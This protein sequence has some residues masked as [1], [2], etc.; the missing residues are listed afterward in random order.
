MAAPGA[1][2]SGPATSGIVGPVAHEVGLDGVEQHEPTGQ[3]PVALGDGDGVAPPR[4]TRVQRVEPV[5]HRP[6][7]VGAGAGEDGVDRLHVLGTADGLVGDHDHLGQDL[8]AEDDVAPL[9]VVGGVRSGIV[10]VTLV[11]DVQHGGQCGRQGVSPPVADA[12]T[13]PGCPGSVP[14]RRRSAVTPARSPRARRGGTPATPGSTAASTPAT[15]DTADQDR[16]PART[17]CVNTNSSSDSSADANAHAHTRPRTSPTAPPMAAMITDSQRTERRSCRRVMPMARSM[18]ISWVRSYTDSASVFTIP[19]TA[20]ELR[21]EQQ[22]HRD[23]EELVDELGLGV[24]RLVCG[25][26]LD[27]REVVAAAPR[28]TASRARAHASTPGR[29]GRVGAVVEVGLGE[30]GRGTAR[31]TRGTASRRRRRHRRR[32]PPPAPART[33]FGNSSGDLVTEGEAVLDRLLLR[34]EHPVVAEVGD[35]AARASAG[36]RRRRAR[37]RSTAT[38]RSSSRRVDD[39]A[40]RPKRKPD[41]AGD[42]GQRVDAGDDVGREPGELRGVDDEVGLERRSRTRRPAPWP[43]RRGS[44]PSRPA[45]GRSRARSRWPRCDAGCASR[46][47]A[48]SRPVTP[49][50]T[51]TGDA[52]HAARAGGRTWRAAPRCRRRGAARRARRSAAR[53]WR[54][55]PTAARAM[56]TSEHRHAHRERARCRRRVRRRNVVGARLGEVADRRHRRDARPP[57][58]RATA[59]R[60]R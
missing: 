29:D 57:G 27:V 43:T 49:A 26:H 24:A 21:Q 6:R 36:R 44:R 38:T 50:A 1:S 2:S 34:H 22:R 32:S 9:G 17:G 4:P 55:R 14:G 15:S 7:A 39:D 28:A 25:E 53:R 5:V 19:S 48:R 11:G 16:R 12:G 8:A 45:R 33:P 56:P 37:D 3:E 10:P 52:E 60:R 47:R 13:L 59:T 20:I 46:C 23:A 51:R 18:P 30:A 40:L 41:R 58:T 42:L 31:A 35:R 54:R